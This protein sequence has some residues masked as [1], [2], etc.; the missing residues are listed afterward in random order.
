[1]CCLRF[2]QNITVVIDRFLSQI[3]TKHTAKITKDKHNTDNYF[4][5]L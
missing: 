4:K 3:V 1:M 5:I 2:V